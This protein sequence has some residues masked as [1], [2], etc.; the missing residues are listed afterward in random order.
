MNLGLPT[1]AAKP[2]DWSLRGY[3]SIIS[4]LGD[5]WKVGVQRNIGS[6]CRASIWPVYQQ[7]YHG[8]HDCPDCYVREGPLHNLV[9]VSFMRFVGLDD[10]SRRV[11]C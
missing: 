4:A 5:A 3:V 11:L 2:R 10:S 9:S 6:G 7:Y 8:E 1:E